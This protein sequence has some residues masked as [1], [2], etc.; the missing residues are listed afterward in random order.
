MLER[1]STVGGMA[2]SFE[3]AGVRVDLGSH[4]LHPSIEPRILA[5]LQAL[6]G[7]D[8]QLRRRNGRLRI[9]ERWVRFPLRPGELARVLPPRLLASAAVEGVVAPL[10]RSAPTSYADALRSGLGPTLYESLYAPF[11]RKLWGLPGEAIDAEQA[12][13]R[14]SA[15][16]LWKVAARVLRPSGGTGRVFHYPAG[17]FGQ[18]AEA[19]ADAATASGADIRLGTRVERVR[20]DTD[21]VRVL[22]AA[23]EALTAS[24]VF[25]TVPLPVLAR[26]AEPAAPPVALRAAA[27]LRFRAM[28]LAYVVHQ[29]RPWSPFDAHYLPD[30]ATPVS[31]V[32]EPANYR[33]SAA[34]P[35]DRTVLCFEIPCEVGDEVW[36]SDEA[37]LLEIVTDAIG[38][39][40]LP[41]LRP[42]GVHV[43][44]LSHVYPVYDI[45][46]QAR[47]QGLDEWADS[48]P[49]VTTFGR[50]GL[51]AHDN[52]HHAMAMAYDAVDALRDGSVDA[53]AWA[54]ARRRFAEHVVE[55]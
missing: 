3:V 13:R 28:V 6:L 2:G 50:L 32:S 12:R 45:G 49:R 52:S 46:Y 11:A 38:R 7:D 51:F 33:S 43:R 40:D 8:L 24:Q 21:A 31:R 39:L 1:E 9:A 26:M 41:A 5:D 4:R 20:A 29:G 53:A 34:D 25:T 42:G 47:L 48:L 30:A 23:G 17:G 10:R 16:T 18:I 37:D 19:L 35:Y 22:T 14:V 54:A 15:D 55:D 44:R 36:T 27:G